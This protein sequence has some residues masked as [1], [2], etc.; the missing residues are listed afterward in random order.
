MFGL[1]QVIKLTNFQTFITEA[2]DFKN[3]TISI[4]RLR[5]MIGSIKIAENYNLVFD[6]YQ[7]TFIQLHEKEFF[8]SAIYVE[9]QLVPSRYFSQ[10]NIIIE[11]LNRYHIFRCQ[12]LNNLIHKNIE[13][14]ATAKLNGFFKYS[15][16]NSSGRI[17]FTNHQQPL[18]ICKNCLLEFNRLNNTNFEIINFNPSFIVSQ[19]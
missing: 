1:G 8:R 14:S 15:F 17:I 3:S 12:N 9:K 13:L 11:N 16:I 6:N 4:D 19:I 2:E 7:Q 10:E 18:L 5:L